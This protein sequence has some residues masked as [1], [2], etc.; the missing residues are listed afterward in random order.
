MSNGKGQSKKSKANPKKKPAPRSVD[1]GRAEKAPVAQSTKNRTQ[2][3]E[4][5]WARDG[6]SC[7]IRHRERVGTTLGSVAFSVANTFAIN[8][9]LA[10]SFPWL[11]A[12]AQRFESYRFERLDFEYKTKTA[13]T[14]TGD[15]ILALDYDAADAAPGS[16]IQAE[17]YAEA[18]SSA[19]WQ[20]LT[21]CSGKVNLSK[22]R[23]RY[24]R[25]GPLDANLDIKTYDVGNMFVC[26]ENQASAA[27]IGYIYVSYDIVLM[28]PQLALNYA[29]LIGGAVSSGGTVSGANPL[30]TTAAVDAQAVGLSVNASSVVTFAF[31]G[32]YLIS[33]ALV[34]TTVSVLTLTAGTGA[35]VNVLVGDT[36]NAGATIVTNAWRV[37]TSTNNATVAFTATAA[38]VTSSQLYIGQVPASSL[39]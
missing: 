11:S 33:G 32:T 1:T 3:P 21:H 34:G 30:G 18:V 13:T 22:L 31:P 5:E 28:T 8:P 23:S 27:L 6:S 24:V 39:S 12:V 38:A 2:H 4:M 26:T 16:S 25:S 17:G 29:G 36:V 10:S 14:T 20:D 15:V 35:A 7:R 37:V 19:P 9:G